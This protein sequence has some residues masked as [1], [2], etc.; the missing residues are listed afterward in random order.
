M[1]IIICEAKIDPARQAEFVEKVNASGVI[2]ATT[3]EAGNI[4][5]ELAVSAGTPGCLYVIERWED[6]A[7]LQAHMKGT[8]FASFG[9]LSAEY[10]VATTI[11]VYDGKPLN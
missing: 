6:M 2:A 11:K 3:Q 8:N 10:G 9:K 4:S 1:I 7:V 5:Y